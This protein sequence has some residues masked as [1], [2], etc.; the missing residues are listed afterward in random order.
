MWVALSMAYVGSGRSTGVTIVVVE[1]GFVSWEQLYQ[2]R[3][4][5]VPGILESTQDTRN[6]GAGLIVCSS[7]RTLSVCVLAQDIMTSRAFRTALIIEGDKNVYNE[8]RRSEKDVRDVVWRGQRG[9]QGE[10][11][12]KGQICVVATCGRLQKVGAAT[13]INDFHPLL[14]HRR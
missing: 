9:G 13:L 4:D 5:F 6:F 3:M 7:T 10:R 14:R 8:R 1:I 12:I 2:K 11:K